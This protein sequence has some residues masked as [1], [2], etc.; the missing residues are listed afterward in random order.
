MCIGLHCQPPSV[1]LIIHYR[2]QSFVMYRMAAALTLIVWWQPDI[3]V[4]FHWPCK[5]ATHS[6]N[7]Q[8]YNIAS[9]AWVPAIVFGT[10]TIM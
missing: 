5:R 1:D 6:R 8:D 4:P 9:K 2:G 3:R 7:I 10:S